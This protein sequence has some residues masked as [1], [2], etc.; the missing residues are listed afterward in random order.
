MARI[1]LYVLTISIVV[2][3]GAFEFG[4]GSA[5]FVT[6][7]GQPGFYIYFELDPTAKRK[8]SGLFSIVVCTESLLIPESTDTADIIS[9]VNGLFYF[10]A[11]VGSLFQSWLADRWGRKAALAVAAT[12]ALIGNALV[13]GSVNVPMLAVVRVIQGGGL[14]MLLSLVPLYLAEVSPPRH[15]GLLTGL[16]TIGFGLGYV[17]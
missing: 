13:A 9:A 5:V 3:V 16:T 11:A 6:S 12:I 15:R 17:M 1:P 14:G 7:L 8:Y 4:F 2:A 10:G